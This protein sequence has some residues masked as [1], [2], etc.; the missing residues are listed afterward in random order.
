[1][2]RAFNDASSQHLSSATTPVTSF[3]L[4]MACW[5]NS[6]DVANG[7]GIMSVCDDTSDNDYFA[8][9]ASGNVGGDPV[10]ASSRST[11]EGADNA[12]TTTGYSANTWHHAAGVF[13]NSTSRAAFI[14]GGSKG[15]NTAANTPA[16]SDQMGIGAIA[17]PTV[18]FYFS[19]RIAEAAIWSAALSDAEVAVLATG[20]S[21]LFVRP[22]SLVAYW[23]LMGLLSPEP[24]IIGKYSMTLNAAPTAGDHVPITYPI[25][26]QSFYFTQTASLDINIAPDNLDIYTAGVQIVG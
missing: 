9:V 10:Q 13:T 21:P 20:I 23:P 22:A 24:D 17:R 4:T 1:M 26:P 25:M 15:T 12:A 8:L 18:F 5:F 14:D 2:A 3:P 6:D 19:G 16:A 11:A 7:Q